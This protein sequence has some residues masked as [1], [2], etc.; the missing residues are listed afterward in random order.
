M[1]TSRDAKLRAAARE[2]GALVIGDCVTT[3][4]AMPVEVDDVGIDIAYSCSQKGLSCPAGL[5]PITMSPRAWEWLQQRKEDTFTWYLDLRLMQKYFDPPHVYQHT[6]SPPLYYALHQGLA[7]IEEEGLRNRWGRHHRAH[8]RLTPG[9]ERL[10]FEFVVKN[11]EHRIWHVNTVRP[12]AGLNEAELRQKLLDKY[13][14]EIASG[15]G[16]FAGKILRIGTIGPLATDESVDF[17]LEAIANS[18]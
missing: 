1:R 11:P 7:A 4:G 2:I 12:P 14:I 17:V 6:P 18:L 3:V 13:A 10:G 9:L 16:E 5:S 15:L 8:K